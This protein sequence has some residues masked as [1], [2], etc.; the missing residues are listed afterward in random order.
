MNL[1]NTIAFNALKRTTFL[2][3]LFYFVY[4]SLFTYL[5]LGHVLPQA[6]SAL[7]LPLETS[8]RL[9]RVKSDIDTKIIIVF[10][11]KFPYFLFAFSLF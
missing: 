4:F 5:Y 1:R 3:S 10:K 2:K 8:R 9:L 7:G 6:Q 11:T